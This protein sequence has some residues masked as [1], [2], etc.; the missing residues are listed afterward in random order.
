VPDYGS[1]RN[2][3]LGRMLTRAGDPGLALLSQGGLQDGD[4]TIFLEI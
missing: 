2:R 4:G 3:H 1:T